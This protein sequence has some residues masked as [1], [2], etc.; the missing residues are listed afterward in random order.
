MARS[1]EQ[2]FGDAL[3][4]V[5]AALEALAK[6]YRPAQLAEV[7]FSLYEQLRPRIPEAVKGW[8]RRGSS[9]SSASA[10]WP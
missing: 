9:T 3:A 4:E 2:R 7:A 1:L 5:R 8:G 10:T 6:A